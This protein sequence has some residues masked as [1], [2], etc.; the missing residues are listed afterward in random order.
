MDANNKRRAL[1]RASRQRS[2]DIVHDDRQLTFVNQ[3]MAQQTLHCTGPRQ[4]AI[5]RIHAGFSTRTGSPA[6]IGRFQ[7]DIG[8]VTLDSAENKLLL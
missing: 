3:D 7:H 5:S 8:R 6:R 2:V 1:F 4:S